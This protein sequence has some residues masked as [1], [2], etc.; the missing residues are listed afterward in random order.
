MPRRTR[1]QIIG[2]AEDIERRERQRAYRDL[3]NELHLDWQE[4]HSVSMAPGVEAYRSVLLN[5]PILFR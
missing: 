3:Q 1:K 5:Q 4:Q 2:V